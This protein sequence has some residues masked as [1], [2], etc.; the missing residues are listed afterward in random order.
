MTR[1]CKGPVHAQMQLTCT[2]RPESG[3]IA[4][5]SR[6]AVRL[7]ANCVGGNSVSVAVTD[8]AVVDELAR[9]RST[10]DSVDDL[11]IA[12]NDVEQLGPHAAWVTRESL[13]NTPSR[14]SPDAASPHCESAMT[15]NEP[16]SGKRR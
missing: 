7:Q 9:V 3:R 1:I 11:D 15:P 8:G 12:V 5:A 4:D 10:T 16:T 14:F 2:Q 13:R 6:P